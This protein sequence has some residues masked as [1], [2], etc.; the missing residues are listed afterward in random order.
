MEFATKIY[1]ERFFLSVS[2]RNRGDVKDFE[3]TEVPY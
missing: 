3:T 1:F 2:V